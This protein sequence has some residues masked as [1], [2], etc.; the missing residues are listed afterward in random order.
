M[1]DH[2]IP[3]RDLI[4]ALHRRRRMI[5]N[6]WISGAAIIAFALL[7][8]GPRYEA[9]AR[10][11]VTN[12]RP[13]TVSP[14]ES[15]QPT[16]KVSDEDL[17][18][19]VSLLSSDALVREVLEPY[20]GSEYEPAEGAFKRFTALPGD[21]VGFVYR[22]LH[23]VPAETAFDRWVEHTTKHL[24]VELVK[25]SN[26]ISVSFG[27]R[28]VSPE[29]TAKLVNDLINHHLQHHDRRSR[30]SD[31]FRFFESQLQMLRDKARDA[32]L[33][34]QSFF[35]REGL[36][37]LPEQRD[38]WRKRLVTLNTDLSDAE[39]ELAASQ[40]RADFLSAE[41]KNHSKVVTESSH[42]AQ[43]QA[44]QFLKPK[45]LEK[46][47]QRSELLSVYAPESSKVV[48]VEKELADAKRLLKQEKE[49]IAEATNSINPTYQAIELDLAQ[50]R[51]TL[52]AAQAKVDSLRAQIVECR[53]KIEHL[54]Q[55]A[56]E[57]DRLQQDVDTA[58]QALAIYAK[59]A[60]QARL[61]SAL[62]DSR[63]V[64]LAVAEPAEVPTAPARSHAILILAAA[65]V[66]SLM[67]AMVLALV[68]DYFD[69]TIKNG[70]QARRATA[71]PV[72]AEVS[73]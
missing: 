29:W 69:P 61:S 27:D 10:L 20:R 32:E 49:T 44:V 22:T 59:K 55:V 58:K 51:A 15:A 63:I 25:K 5:A 60:E 73:S 57:H 41:I 52:S 68:R 50:T 21:V 11:M 1:T 2:E 43:N 23:G 34:Q 62:D 54:D 72:L 26:L 64:N 53:A 37:S 39:R 7:M 14:D 48:A 16:E 38:T 8:M 66:L 35:Q 3:W 70:L 9:T 46:E 71:L 33:A 42:L 24:D 56:S 67:A 36:D 28:S 13:L 6:V 18:A 19:E 47:I 12:D 31:A 30:Q 40:A 4:A 45:V 65:I 17:N